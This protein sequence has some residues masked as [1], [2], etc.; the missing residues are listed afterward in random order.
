M[1]DHIQDAIEQ[2][3]SIKYALETFRSPIN[4]DGLQT[5]VESAYQCLNFAWNI[6]HLSQEKYW[7]VC[8]DESRF[9]AMRKLPTDLSYETEQ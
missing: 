6:R 4:Q 2:L 7:S 8:E 3:E 9:Q 5:E 1:I